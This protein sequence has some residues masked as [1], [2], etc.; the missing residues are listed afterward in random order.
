MSNR[1]KYL[2]KCSLGLF[3]VG[4]KRDSKEF[5]HSSRA[6]SLSD[7]FPPSLS[8]RPP[9][10]A[11]REWLL[12][13]SFLRRRGITSSSSSSI[14]TS[15]IGRVRVS[16]R[17]PAT[18][19]AAP[20]GALSLL[21]RFR[22]RLPILPPRRRRPEGAFP[23]RRRCSLLLNSSPGA[24]GAPR[25]PRASPRRRSGSGSASERH[26]RRPR[27]RGRGPLSCRCRHRPCP[28]RPRPSTPR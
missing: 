26:R 15:S 3:L 12:L 25:E 8:S 19:A 24:P 17:S 5:Q 11:G 10:Y 22:P 20:P 16:S 4:T 9:S 23:C 6:P 21:L 14:G 27:S 28:P 2:A 1:R 18:M 7:P 13:R